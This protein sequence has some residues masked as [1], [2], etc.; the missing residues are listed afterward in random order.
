MEYYYTDARGKRR[1]GYFIPRFESFRRLE[2]GLPG[3]TGLEGGKRVQM[4]VYNPYPEAIPLSKLRFG[5]AWLDAYKRLLEVRPLQLALPRVQ[6]LPSRD[7]L[8]FEIVLPAPE[9]SLPE[10]ARAVISENGLYWGLNG[11]AQPVN[12]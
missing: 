6:A 10:Y 11:P 3:D 5:V 1:Y 2:T 9:K 4:W 7:S 12:P 8:R